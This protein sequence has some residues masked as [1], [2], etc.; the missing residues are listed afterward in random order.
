MDYLSPMVKVD[1]IIKFSEQ[2]HTLVRMKMFFYA[3]M[4]RGIFEQLQQISY[5]QYTN[6]KDANQ[7]YNKMIHNLEVV[8][9]IAESFL[10]EMEQDEE[11]ELNGTRT[12]RSRV[13]HNS[14]NQFLS[15]KNNR[16]T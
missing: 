6:E 1:Y 16:R 12:G 9:G 13:S 8:N 3:H 2:V 5:I 7:K 14:S 10:L 4:F 11:D 15:I